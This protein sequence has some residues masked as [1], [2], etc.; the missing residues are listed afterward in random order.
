[1]DQRATDP[2]ALQIM[3]SQRE[4]PGVT[5]QVQ[6]VIYY[7]QPYSTDAAQMLGYLQPITPQEVKQRHLPV[8]G[9]SGV[10]LVGQAGLE[11]QYDQQL[12]GTPGP[13]VLSVNAAGEVTAVH[14]Q[15]PAVAGDTLVTSINS[16]LEQD[17][18]N[19]PGQAIQHAQ[20]EGNPG[21]D[22]RRGS[23]DDHQGPDRRDGQLPD[24]QPQ[25]VDRRHLQLRV[26]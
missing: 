19:G 6:P 22:Q 11:E 1:M 25:C 23:G 12:R 7:Q 21:R 13:Q 4:F 5:A 20:A 17:T 3:E 15:T 26:P 18:E 9:F 10:D 14:H 16:Q 8:T 24:L 2:I